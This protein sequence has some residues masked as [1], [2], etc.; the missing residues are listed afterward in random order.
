[1][2]H[3]KAGHSCVLPFLALAEFAGVLRTSVNPAF[4]KI[5]GQPS[6]AP[7]F[8]RQSSKVPPTVAG[9]AARS[10]CTGSGLLNLG[11]LAPVF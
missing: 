10:C 4:P 9:R 3:I 8:M 2:R 7:C 1:M 11:I 6:D 5:D